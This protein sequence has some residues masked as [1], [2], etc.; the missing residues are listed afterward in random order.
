[1][2]SIIVRHAPIS[3]K[4]IVV[5]A[6]TKKDGQVEIFTEGQRRTVGLD[7]YQAT[8]PVSIEDAKRVAHEYAKANNM[9]VE[10]VMLRQRFPKT[11]TQ[12]KKNAGGRQRKTNDANLRLVD[13]EKNGDKQSLAKAAQALHDKETKPQEQENK[14]RADDKR[15]TP[16]NPEG[17]VVQRTK[18]PY[19]KK[20]DK[21]LS[22]RSAAAMKRY[23]QELA[24]TASQSPT[25]MEG[26]A[27]QLPQGE[28]EKE[29]ADLTAE[30][31][32]ILLKNPGVL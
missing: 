13:N 29:V 12:P 8:E 32:K 1:M 19:N 15:S 23:Q 27:H 6:D 28:F 11:N 17:A 18:R 3:D 10:E 25:M 20:G 7:Y 24:K 9:P 5:M 4:I 16:E 2:Q 21:E 31:V 26:V 22:K 14:R 30:I